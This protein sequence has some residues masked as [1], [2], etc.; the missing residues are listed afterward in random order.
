MFDLYE[1]NPSL[2][3]FSLSDPN[4]TLYTKWWQ[5]AEPIWT[6]ATKH[7]KSSFLRN[8]SRCDVP[9]KGVLPSDCIGYGSENNVD[10]ARNT[11]ENVGTA[12]A[13]GFDL[14]MVHVDFLDHAGHHGGPDSDEL[15]EA[16][17]ALDGFLGSLLETL[18]ENRLSQKVSTVV[19]PNRL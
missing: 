2:A 4:T 15:R 10:D 8:W 1:T 7:G 18:D 17:I 5:K 3:T 11:I 6:T 19:F 13:K 9:F 14:V 16:L 12:L